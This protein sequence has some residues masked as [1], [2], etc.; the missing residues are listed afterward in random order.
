[1]GQTQA[2]TGPT[3]AGGRTPSTPRFDRG[4]WLGLTLSALMLAAFELA[5]GA[6]RGWAGHAA[7]DYELYVGV[8]RRWLSGG[9]FYQAWQLSGPYGVS[10][11]YG[12]VLYPPIDLWLFGAFTFLPAVL[13]WIL[14]LGA[15]AWTVWRHQPDP[16]AWPLMAL[17][18]AWPPSIV[19]LVTGNPVMWA[20]AGVALGTIYAWPAVFALLKPSVFP[21]ALL[22]IRSRGWWLGVVVLVV[23]S[24]PFGGMWATWLTTVLNARDGGLLYS[25]QEIPLL[26]LPL[27]AWAARRRTLG[28]SRVGSPAASVRRFRGWAGGNAG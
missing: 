13:W 7:G 1:M 11:P 17:C 26:A 3:T 12:A 24:V 6:A 16:R 9:D 4:V 18:L 2:M 22:G 10:D 27:I 25:V 19:K 20:V 14:P 21:F 23:A 8:A 15:V 5:A 28:E